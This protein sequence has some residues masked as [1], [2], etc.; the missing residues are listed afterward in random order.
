MRNV[1]KLLPPE[2]VL[3]I[4]LSSYACTLSFFFFVYIVLKLSCKK[5]AHFRNVEAGAKLFLVVMASAKVHIAE[6]WLGSRGKFLTA[7]WLQ[8]PFSLLRKTELV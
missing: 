3:I 5:T 2:V 6:L 7:D 4:D 1:Y 8:A